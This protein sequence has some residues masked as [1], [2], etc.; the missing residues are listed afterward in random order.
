MKGVFIVYLFMKPNRDAYIY[1]HAP[2]TL[3]GEMG[4]VTRNCLP[5]QG[6]VTSSEIPIHT[7]I[8]ELLPLPICE[9][10]S[11]VQFSNLLFACLI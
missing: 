4:H 8:L 7:N 2:L 3:A 11:P 10:F 6:S 1:I 9:T 5:G